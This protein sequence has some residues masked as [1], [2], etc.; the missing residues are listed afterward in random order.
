MS[1]LRFL[2]IDF[3]ASFEEY[4]QIISHDGKEIAFVGA[5]N[6]GKSS[7]INALAN[8]SKL[9]KVS[10]KP[11]KT[12]LFNFFRLE[13]GFIVDF[14]GYGYA[15]TSKDQ[16]KIWS[17]ELPQYFEK[18]PNLSFAYLFSDIRHPLKDSD[19]QMLELLTK[20]QIGHK[21]IFT[22]CDKIKSQEIPEILDGQKKGLP[23]VDFFS[24][25]DKSQILK[26]ASEINE[27]LS[28]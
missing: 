19:Y 15:K 2:N 22:K 27:L 10:K 6:S 8:K 5:S 3:F 13:R 24:I 21:V 11:G 25:K 20:N 7:A 28:N 14:P 9:A 1:S 18:R 4:H 23:Q 17:I 16:K 26:I 12:K